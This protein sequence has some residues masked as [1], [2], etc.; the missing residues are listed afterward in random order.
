M[1]RLFVWVHQL[2]VSFDPHRQQPPPAYHLASQTDI[3]PFHLLLCPTVHLFA[4][5]L[6]PDYLYWLA[7]WWRFRCE[8][9]LAKFRF[10]WTWFLILALLVFFASYPL[11]AAVDYWVVWSQPPC[12]CYCRCL[13]WNGGVWCS[14]SIDQRLCQFSL[15]PYSFL[16]H[17]LNHRSVL[18]KR[19][20]QNRL[21]F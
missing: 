17:F 12:Y 6:C 20:K 16:S 8:W 4:C 7:G 18:S 19:N 9:L 5:R 2:I 13:K 14:S 11:F 1:T 3:Q 10:H 15:W 21:V